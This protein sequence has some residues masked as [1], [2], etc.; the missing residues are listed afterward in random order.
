ME[1][2]APTLFAFTGTLFCILLVHHVHV[3]DQAR[4]PDRIGSVGEAV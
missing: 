1:K 3:V 4:I 2:N